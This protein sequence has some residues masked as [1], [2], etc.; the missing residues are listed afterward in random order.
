MKIF[1]RAKSDPP[2]NARRSETFRVN[3]S[4]RNRICDAVPAA[5]IVSS[6]IVTPGITDRLP[7]YPGQVNISRLFKVID[8]AVSNT[9][10]ISIKLF[11]IA[12]VQK[13]CLSS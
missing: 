7:C 6:K 8:M 2:E 5:I 13:L 1:H 12:G 3:F 9:C 11:C 4:G 10:A